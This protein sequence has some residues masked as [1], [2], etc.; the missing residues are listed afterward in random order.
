MNIYDSGTGLWNK[1]AYFECSSK[2]D[3]N[4]NFTPNFLQALFW[5]EKITSGGASGGSISSGSS[6]KTMA[7]SGTGPAST[8]LIGKQLI[9][10]FMCHSGP[11]DQ[12]TKTN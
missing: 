7:R 10:I 3:S 12:W 5:Q 9:V 1:F 11:V 6:S 4:L 2:F 8:D